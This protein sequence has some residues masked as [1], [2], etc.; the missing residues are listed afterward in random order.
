MSRAWFPSGADL[1]RPA[2][3]GPSPVLD[4]RPARPFR[5]VIV[6]LESQPG[7]KRTLGG[8]RRGD[9][10]GAERATLTTLRGGVRR[11]AGGGKRL[12][13]PAARRPPPATSSPTR[14]AG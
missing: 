12:F 10:A 3:G 2:S 13:L 6:P 8:P 4:G 14:R 5:D 1:P 9:G 11:A 7:K